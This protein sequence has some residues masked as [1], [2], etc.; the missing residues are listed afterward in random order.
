[1]NK[2]VLFA[3]KKHK[4]EKFDCGIN[5]LNLFI[6]QFAWQQQK[7]HVGRTFVINN[8]NNEVIS[9]YT[10]SAGSIRHEEAPTALAKN[11]PKYPI[12]TVLLGRLAI[13]KTEQGKGLGAL[14][15]RDVLFRVS[16]VADNLD[17]V[18]LTVDAKN[19]KAVAFYK[20]YG[21]IAFNSKPF[22]L[23]MPLKT[24]KQIINKHK[25]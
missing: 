22:T 24:I 15:L 12:P 25:K 10:L 4:T 6:K 3:N 8:K 17:V 16:N 19:K 1:M 23:F 13:H 21:F 2:I 18:A 7:K 11:L 5:S 14:L 20:Q 9:F